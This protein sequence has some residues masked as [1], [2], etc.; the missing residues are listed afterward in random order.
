M[1][2][3]FNCT[4]ETK[5]L[6]DRLVATGSYREYGEAIAASVRNQVLMEQEVASRGPIVIA[7]APSAP[8]QPMPEPDRDEPQPAKPAAAAKPA[9]KAAAPRKA[10]VVAKDSDNGFTYLFQVKESR[11]EFARVPE[12]FQRGGLPST[13]PKGLAELPF[14]MWAAGQ[15]VPLSDADG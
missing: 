11:G 8:Q 5:D 7:S 12:L 15:P 2:I 14:D 13:P 3:C 9:R 10:D 4:A 6:L 1:I